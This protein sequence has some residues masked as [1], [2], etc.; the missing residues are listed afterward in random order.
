M[1]PGFSCDIFSLFFPSN[2]L[3]TLK[4]LS[5]CTRGRGG[6]GPGYM[7]SGA[8]W[9]WFHFWVLAPPLLALDAAQVPHPVFT[10]SSIVLAVQQP[11]EWHLP[12]GV[13]VR[14]PCNQMW[15]VP[16][17]P[18]GS[19]SLTDRLGDRPSLVQ[20]PKWCLARNRA[21]WEPVLNK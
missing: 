12:H 9:L 1:C 14:M 20:H 21:Q 5:E 16:G 15:Q 19:V 4:A 10:S 18:H 7:V 2:L 6:L 3:K 13:A 17:S 8:E 11:W